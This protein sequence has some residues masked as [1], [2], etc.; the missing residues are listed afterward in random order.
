VKMGGYWSYFCMARLF[1]VRG[2]ALLFIFVGNRR[3]PTETVSAGHLEECRSWLSKCEQKCYLAKKTKWFYIYFKNVMG[4][5]WFQTM[6]RA[7]VQK[8]FDPNALGTFSFFAHCLC[9]DWTRNRLWT[10]CPSGSERAGVKFCVT[11][12]CEIFD[13]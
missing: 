1:A 3:N 10:A 13:G 8:R 6:R 12:L 9:L 4:L 5:E 2:S 7:Q 11:V